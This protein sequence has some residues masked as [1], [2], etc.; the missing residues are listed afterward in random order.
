M[1]TTHKKHFSEMERTSWM[2]ILSSPLLTLRTV[3][4]GRS[5]GESLLRYT[6][7]LLKGPDLINKE[8]A[9]CIC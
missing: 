9:R 7:P 5:C 6:W 8:L 4:K 1:A 2:T 3:L